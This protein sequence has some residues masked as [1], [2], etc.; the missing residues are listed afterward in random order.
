MTKTER[1]D[2]RVRQA[3]FAERMAAAGYVL[4][5]EWVHQSE[6]WRVKAYAAKLNKARGDD[7]RRGKT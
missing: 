1:A 4:S 6:A 3:A 5:R 7:P 2:N